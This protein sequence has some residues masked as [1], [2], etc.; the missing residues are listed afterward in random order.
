ME[1][2]LQHI[3]QLIP[4][5]RA[6]VGLIDVAKGEGVIFA[7]DYDGDTPLGQGLHIPVSQDF[8]DGYNQQ[9]I[10]VIPDLR[11][12]QETNPRFKQAVKD[13]LRSGLNV[14]LL[15]VV[16]NLIGTLGLFADTPDFFTPEHQE[17]MLE[18][19][20]QLAIGHAVKCNCRHN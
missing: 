15:I 7:V 2:A 5:Q 6:N 18:V 1:V 14:L 19:G 20:S 13:G 16:T 17:I 12:V 3:R 11:V 4:C 9:H 8:F 10:K